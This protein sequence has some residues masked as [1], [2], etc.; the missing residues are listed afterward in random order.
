MLVIKPSYMLGSFLLILLLRR[1]R[2]TA[3]SSL[4][5]GLAAFLAGEGACALESFV[6]GS[7]VL[8]NYF[9]GFGMAAAFALVTFSILAA[10]DRYV[11]RYGTSKRCALKPS[12]PKCIKLGPAPCLARRL[13]ALCAALLGL[14]ALVPLWVTISPIAY[15]TIVFDTPVPYAHTGAAQLFELRYLPLLSTVLSWTS[16]I[17]FLRHEKESLRWAKVLFSGG[18][19]GLAFAYFR[20]TL[21]SALRPVLLWKVF[22]EETTELMFIVGTWVLLVLLLTRPEQR[23]VAR[24][25]L[26]APVTPPA[27]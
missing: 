7:S 9:H 4:R 1:H 27:E 22:W 25:L 23:A 19:G 3:L 21:V 13:Y 17:I 24:L 11:V 6:I 12:C 15:E 5:W 14:L 16:A 18:V 8:L 2:D 10:L 26:K 20:L